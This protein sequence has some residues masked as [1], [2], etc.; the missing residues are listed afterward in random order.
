MRIRACVTGND[1]KHDGDGT[2]DDD[3]DDSNNDDDDLLLFPLPH[4]ARVVYLR[5]RP[6]ER[7]HDTHTR[8]SIRVPNFRSTRTILFLS[9]ADEIRPPDL[10]RSRAS[11]NERE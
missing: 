4:L 7:N 6:T 10:R 2:E 1:D 8:A 3:D 11:E 5:E 9:R